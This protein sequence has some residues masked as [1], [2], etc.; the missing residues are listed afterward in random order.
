MMMTD[1][2]PKALTRLP[3]FSASG[4]SGGSPNARPAAADT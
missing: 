3:A 4:F 1:A 2:I